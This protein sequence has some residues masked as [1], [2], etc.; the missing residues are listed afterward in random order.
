MIDDAKFE[1]LIEDSFDEVNNGVEGVQYMT[2]YKWAARAVAAKF[3]GKDQHEITE[4]SHEA[5]EHAALV[6]D[7]SV[8]K[9][10]RAIFKQLQITT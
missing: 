5:L 7:E 3:L 2:A 9:Q 6:N 10:V 4:Y 8:L 1:Q